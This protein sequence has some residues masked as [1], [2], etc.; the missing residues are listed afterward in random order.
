MK[1]L[2]TY[3]SDNGKFKGTK[4]EVKKY[5]EELARKEKLAKEKQDR[6]DEIAEAEQKL[7]DL[8]DKY[9][10]DYPNDRYYGIELDDVFKR[11]FNL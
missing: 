4:E 10:K 3:I 5:E 1:P 2:E 8:E 6:L 7:K 9:Y 11:L